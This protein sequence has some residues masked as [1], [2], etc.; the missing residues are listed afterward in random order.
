MKNFQ[1]E[2]FKSL[3]NIG[4]SGLLKIYNNSLI[5]MLS[6][7]LP[8]LSWEKWKFT[9]SKHKWDQNTAKQF[10]EMAG[11]QLGIKQLSDWY[12]MKPTVSFQKYKIPIL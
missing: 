7:I 10:L 3:V 2:S 1:V 11:K 5:K 8:E 12:T 4:G 6:N 9:Y